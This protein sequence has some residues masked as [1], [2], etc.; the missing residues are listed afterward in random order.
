MIRGSEKDELSSGVAFEVPEE[1]LLT[2]G[3]AGIS[4]IDNTG[5]L[6]GIRFRESENGK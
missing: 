1:G 5:D 6:G 2:C 3:S 4:G